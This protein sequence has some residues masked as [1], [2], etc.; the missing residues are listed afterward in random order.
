M[1][2]IYYG[3]DLYVNVRRDVLTFQSN[4]F[5]GASL[6]KSQKGFIVD[7]RLGSK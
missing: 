5:G 7:V 3:T 2:I 4:I 6:L 1:Y